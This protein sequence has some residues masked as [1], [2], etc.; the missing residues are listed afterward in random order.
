MVFIS[1]QDIMFNSKEIINRLKKVL[2]IKNDYELAIFLD[3]KQSTLSGWKSRNSFD[4]RDI[5]TKLDKINL[6]YMIKGDNENNQSSGE[7]Q[8]TGENQSK[9]SERNIE[10]INSLKE[11]ITYLL[12]QNEKLLSQIIKVQ[13]QNSKAQDQNTK[14]TEILEKAH[15]KNEELSDKLESSRNASSPSKIRHSVT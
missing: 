15:Q 11:Q 4:I 2:N 14:L 3:I 8:S 1:K 13:E 10:L 12:S 7:G 6:D 5:I 9:L